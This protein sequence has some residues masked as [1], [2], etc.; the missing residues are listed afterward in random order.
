[1]TPRHVA[2]SVW[3]EYMRFRPSFGSLI[4]P[5]FYPL[6]W[7]DDQV[8]GGNFKLLNTSNSAILITVKAYPSGALELHGIAACGNLAEIVG[9]L[10][11]KALEIGKTLGCQIAA[12][13][14][15]PGWA[16]IMRNFGWELHQVA[17]RKAL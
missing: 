9:D 13:E 10:I 1:M 2:E 11:P 12:I 17:L 8:R 5:E 4:D 6:E 7:L 3:D 16:R 15:R 14:S